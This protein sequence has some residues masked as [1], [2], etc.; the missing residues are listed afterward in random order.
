MR[1][2]VILIL[3]L[4]FSLNGKSQQLTKDTIH[5]TGAIMD[6]AELKLISAAKFRVNSSFA[7][8]TDKFGRFSLWANKGDTI[9]YS[10]IGY[11]DIQ[12][13]VSDDLHENNYLFGVFMSKDTVLLQEVLVVPRFGSL[14]HEMQ[15]AKINTK[16][17]VRAVNNVNSAV[18]SALTQKP[19]RRIMNAEDN[20]NFVIKQYTYKNINKTFI[21]EQDMFGVSTFATVK[22]V[23]DMKRK[24][25]MKYNKNI[26][27]EEEI[28]IL[29]NL[30]KNK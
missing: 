29:K 23:K 3:F 9:T 14:R 4:F 6:Q 7:G 25:E 10:H 21:G 12:I 28:Q 22:Y 8:H 5:F 26:I 2:Y 18:Y 16:E 13:L 17:Y 27:N 20:S 30:F 19:H 15:N 11:K 24:R 1:L